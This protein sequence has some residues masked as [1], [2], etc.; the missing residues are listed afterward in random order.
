MS[1]SVRGN[2]PPGGCRSLFIYIRARKYIILYSWL[3]R[4]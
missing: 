4:E 1:M 2:R 3:T